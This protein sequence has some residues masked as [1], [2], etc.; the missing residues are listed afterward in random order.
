MVKPV[1]LK[2]A[3]LI[4]TGA[5][6]VDESVTGS[7]DEV[8]IVTFP[9]AKIAVLMVS[10]GTFAAVACSCIEKVLETPPALAVKLTAC[11]VVT[12]ETIAVNP[13]LVAPAGTVTVVGTV[14]AALPLVRPT[15]KPPL[16]AAELNVAVQESV[17]DPAREALPQEIALNDAEAP[18]LVPPLAVLVV[19]VVLP[20]DALPQPETATAIK[21]Q[22]DN[23]NSFTHNPSS[24]LSNVRLRRNHAL[25]NVLTSVDASALPKPPDKHFEWGT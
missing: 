23:A 25:N 1:P 22:A 9:K 6:P 5:V 17:A 8:L 19:L 4:V 12:A 14:T 15:L 18:V 2:L 20:P 10:A 11:A 7:V 16:P 3:E 13:T 21:E 24:M